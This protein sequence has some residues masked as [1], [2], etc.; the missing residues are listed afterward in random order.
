MA[1]VGPQVPLLAGQV[2]RLFFDRQMSKVDIAAKLGISRF[3]V[4]R[5]V[6]LALTEGLVRIEFRDMP[7]TDLDLAKTLEERWGLDLCVAVESSSRPG[8]LPV[9]VAQAA[10]AVLDDMISSGVTVGIAW[11]S[12]LSAF[13]DA[14]P[15]RQDSSVTVVQLAGSSVRIIR[16]R[17]P[18]ELA[19]RLADRLGAACL[20]L[21][22]PAFVESREV[23]DTLFRQADLRPTV[24]AFDRVDIAL[25]GIGALGNG[26]HGAMSSLVQS[27]VLTG[28]EL[29][30]LREGGAIGDLILSP[31][32]R[33]GR[34]VA[35]EL[36][37][38][39]V[40]ISVEQLARAAHVVALAAGRHKAEAIRGALASGIIRILITDTAAARAIVKLDSWTLREPRAKRRLRGQQAESANSDENQRHPAV[41]EGRHET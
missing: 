15:S 23:R 2:A 26:R 34:F 24:E 10:A 8:T 29:A 31:F 13:V 19:R 7:R 38:R 41:V 25:I 14:L 27:G 33:E 5:L 3:R 40:S 36:A 16:E 9:E 17:A 20:P 32:D 18:G 12:T 37:D 6:D 22:A 28:D 4:A 30:S 11:G 1:A 39:S 35:R 21:Y